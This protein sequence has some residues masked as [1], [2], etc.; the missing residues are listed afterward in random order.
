MRNAKLVSKQLEAEE[1]T[2]AALT[3]RQG[4]RSVSLDR[5]PIIKPVLAK[6]EG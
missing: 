4:G 5:E 1:L 3:A 2:G 6:E